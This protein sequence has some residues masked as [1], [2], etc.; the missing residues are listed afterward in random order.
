MAMLQAG[1]HAMR[2]KDRQRIDYAKFRVVLGTM[3]T[4]TL[5]SQVTRLNMTTQLNDRYNCWKLT[6]NDI[7]IAQNKE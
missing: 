3:G 6:S 1:R 2:M 7:E 4:Y 5:C